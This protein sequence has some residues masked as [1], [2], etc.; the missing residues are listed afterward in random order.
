MTVDHPRKIVPNPDR[1]PKGT[2]LNWK[3]SP[4]GARSAAF[5]HG[6]RANAIFW[7]KRGENYYDA[8]DRVRI[9]REHDEAIERFLQARGL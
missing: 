9:A 6:N 5:L 3:G 4:L 8:V 7:I 1:I 2:L